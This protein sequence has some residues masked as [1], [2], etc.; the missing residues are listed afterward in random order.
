MN[1]TPFQRGLAE[2][3]SLR[4]CCTFSHITGQGSEKIVILMGIQSLASNLLP[5]EKV[6]LVTFLPRI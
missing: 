4:S 2:G 3:T 1:D 6:K 5:G